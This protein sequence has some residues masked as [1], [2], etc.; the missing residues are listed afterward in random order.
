VKVSI[1]TVL[2]VLLP[3]LH[4]ITACLS[5]KYSSATGTVESGNPTKCATACGISTC[6]DCVKGKYSGDTGRTEVAD[7]KVRVTDFEQCICVDVNTNELS[8]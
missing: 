8:F 2:T 4:S 7:C 6:L 1:L 3:S 5:G